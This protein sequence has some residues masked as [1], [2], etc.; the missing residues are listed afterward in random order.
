M[1]AAVE[2]EAAAEA[3]IA[4]VSASTAHRPSGIHEINPEGLGSSSS[5][6]GSSMHSNPGSEACVDGDGGD[7]TDAVAVSPLDDELIAKTM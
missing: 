5:A 1:P 2:A 6:H 4:R 3:A 7:G